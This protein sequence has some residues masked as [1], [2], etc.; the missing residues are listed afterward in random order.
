MCSQHCVLC[1]HFLLIRFTSPPS[2]LK[3]P[4]SL[5]KTRKETLLETHIAALFP[6]VS[7]LFFHLEKSCP[8]SLVAENREGSEMLDLFSSK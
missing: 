2:T 6:T 4:L 5:G 8:A 1:E 7:R 3:K